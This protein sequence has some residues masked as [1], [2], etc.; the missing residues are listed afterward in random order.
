[1]SSLSSKEDRLF[2]LYP[3]F[4][5]KLAFSITNT[6]KIFIKRRKGKLE[7]L[8][9]QNVIY[10]I[11]YDDYETSYVGQTK[12]KLGTRIREHISDIKKR[13]LVLHL[14]YPT[15]ISI[16][17]TISGIGFSISGIL[18]LRF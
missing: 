17:I 8:S 16:L 10:K 14:S 2:H 13:V 18:E 12:R 9:N 15:I 6:L 7:L 11:S 4:Y 5:C 3:T 1:M